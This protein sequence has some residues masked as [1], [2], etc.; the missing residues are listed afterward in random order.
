M[1]KPKKQP[2]DWQAIEKEYVEA[3]S[4]ASRPSLEDLAAKYGCSPSYLREKASN[5][6]WKEKADQFLKQISQVRREKKAV[7][8]G[9]DQ[10]SWDTECLGVA[11][12]L[13]AELQ[14]QAA[15]MALDAKDIDALTR[16][17]E[18]I[19][20]L[21]RAILETQ[22]QTAS[23]TAEIASANEYSQMSIEQL[24]RLYMERSKR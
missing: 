10:A 14:H 6:K 22:A 8:L 24:T 15:V 1:G 5:G 23:N 17:L 2:H 11:Q 12:S 19:H 7:K 13:L 9:T 18:R 21:G 4:E 20:N 3:T 16:S